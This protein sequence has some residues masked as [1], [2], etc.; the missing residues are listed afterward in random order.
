MTEGF[1]PH[2]HSTDPKAG[3]KRDCGCGCN[4]SGDCE[5][6][7]KPQS[8]A[9]RSFLLG[10]GTTALATLVNHRAFAQNAVCGPLSHA[11][12]L[13]PSAAE[14]T[15][16]CG[17]LT[18]GYWANSEDVAGYVLGI[19]GLNQGCDSNLSSEL[20]KIKLGDKLPALAMIDS[21]SAGKNFCNAW[22]TP[23]SDAFHWAGAILCTLSPQYNPHYGYTSGT[24]PGS[25]NQA[26]LDAVANGLSPSQILTAISSIENDYMTG[27]PNFPGG[28]NCKPCAVHV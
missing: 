27:G 7:K 11:A 14:I 23:R 15:S 18:P 19:W 6:A 25:L 16:Q 22:V 4:G 3:P 21:V 13:A 26:I 8:R 24:G 9:R 2:E 10:T 5:E 20:A 1:H 28:T 17:G 12:S